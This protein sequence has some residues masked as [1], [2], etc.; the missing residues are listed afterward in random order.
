MKLVL[1]IWQYIYL[2]QKNKGNVDQRLRSSSDEA[3]KK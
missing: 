1:P 2:Q 3:Q